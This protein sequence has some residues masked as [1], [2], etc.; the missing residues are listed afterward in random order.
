[1]EN[2]VY[3]GGAPENEPGGAGSLPEAADAETVINIRT[4]KT[5]NDRFMIMR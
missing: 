4:V 5:A 2:F 3:C 1:M